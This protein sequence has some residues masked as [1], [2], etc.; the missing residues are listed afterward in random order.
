M[1]EQTKNA[2]NAVNNPVI[3]I[4][5]ASAVGD[6]QQISFETYADAATPVDLLNAL[7]DKLFYVANRQNEVAT[8]KGLELL[9]ETEENHLSAMMADVERQNKRVDDMRNNHPAH[10]RTKFELPL[11]EKQALE[12]IKVNISERKRR[13]EKLKEDINTRKVSVGQK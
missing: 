5:I 8:I 6:K 11:K 9:L 12:N 7:T 10:L 1:S 2:A 4:S 13:I 3:R